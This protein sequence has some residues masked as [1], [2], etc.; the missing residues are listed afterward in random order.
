MIRPTDD[1]RIR[2]IR[3]LIPP[4]IL[5][6]ELPITDRSASTVSETRAAVAAVLRGEDPRLVAVVGPCSIHD[7]QGAFDYAAR[8]KA[9]S[10]PGEWLD[11]LAHELEGVSRVDE[12]TYR[13]TLKGLYPQFVYWLAM[14]FFASMPWEAEKFY[15]QPGLAEKNLTLNYWPVGTGPYMLTEYQENRRHVLSAI[16]SNAHPRFPTRSAARN[17]LAST[18]LSKLP[19]QPYPTG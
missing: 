4:A 7:D 3:P 11:L 15:A 2:E 19:S 6:E 17:T 14:P 1:L 12:H 10:K 5:V 13:V 9:A 8:L 16:S 18:S